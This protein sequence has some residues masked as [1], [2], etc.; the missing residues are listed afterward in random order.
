[1]LLDLL[2]QRR[3]QLRCPGARRS[4]ICTA[5]G[6]SGADADVEAAPRSPASSAGAGRP[7][8]AASAGRRRRRRSESRPEIIARLII[9]HALRRLAARDDAGAAPSAPCRAPRAS[10]TAISGV[11]STLTSPETTSR[12]N[13]RVERARLPDQALV[14][15]APGLDLLVRV[16]ADARARSRTARRASPRRRSRRPRGR[17]RASGRRSCGRGSRP[18][19]ARCGRC[20][21]TRRSTE[22]DVRACSRSVTLGAEH[23]VRRRRSR[24]AR[25]GSSCR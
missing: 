24:R 1:M 2:L 23:R 12:A 22:R 16:D 7:P 3:R 14:E 10:R 21:S 18:R 5:S 15:L 4:W 20:T 19:R 13:R 11:R 25:C 6:S 8:P 9:R 17:A